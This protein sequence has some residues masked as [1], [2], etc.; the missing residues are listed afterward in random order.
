MATTVD[1]Y[2]VKVTVEGREGLKNLKQ[3]MEG[4]SQIGGPLG[5][6][7]NGIL[8]KLGPLGMAAGL[9]ATAFAALGGKALSLAADL[10]DIAGATGIATGTLLNFRQSVVEAGG[11][12]EDFAQIASKLNQSVQE[13]NSGNEKFQK[14]FQDLGVFVTDANGKLRP[15]EEILRDITQRF[16]GGELTSKQYAAAIDILGKNINKLELSKLQAV[17]DPIKTEQIKQI[18]RYN[19]AIDKLTEKINSGLITAFGKLAIAI[20]NAFDT[21]NFAK[22]E[23]EA[24]KRGETYRERTEGFMNRPL[25]G[26][27]PEPLSGQSVPVPERLRQMTEKE[28]AAYKAR[29]DA[30]AA[31]ANE[32]QRQINRGANAVAGGK[33]GFGET[34]EAVLKARADSEKKINELRI[35]QSRQTNLRLNSERLA[36]ILLFSDQQ[37]AAEQRAESSIKDIKINTQA[38]IAKARLDI[39]AQE[40]L[41]EAEKN[42][43]FAAKEKELKLKEAADIAKSRVQITEQL[44]REQERIQDIITQSKA[45]VEEETRL[46]DV[47]AQRNQFS[48][49]NATATD[50]ERERAQKLF[51]LEEERLRVLRQIA[52]IK[53]IPPAERLAREQEINEIFAQRRQLTVEQQDADRNLQRDFASGFEKAYKQYAEDARDSFA[54]AGRLFQGLTQGMEDAFVDF[55]KTGKFEF[56]GLINMMLEE[57]LRSQIRQLMAGLFTGGTSSGGGGLLGGKIIPGILAGGGPVSSRRPYIVGEQGPELFVP[58]SAG[59]MMPNRD[60]GGGTSVTYNINAVDAPSFQAMIARDPSFIHAVAMQG[61]KGTPRRR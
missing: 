56:K 47:L 49:D 32:M 60:I 31:H 36:A 54:L 27:E 42:K 11:K 45:R 39:F 38:E 40:K 61:A 35:E 25:F 48:I 24:N 9:A 52:L 37:T 10:S 15:T 59:S 57:L 41:T 30:A 44:Q 23:E 14:S 53:D 7:I 28:K 33:G 58:N 50:K 29:Q 8:G 5:G 26:Q 51:D 55:A 17:A 34:P 21:S 12:A 2:K 19:E 46:N 18:D 6:T 13:A 20:N 1:N 4:L 16:Q 43:E 3:D 22:L